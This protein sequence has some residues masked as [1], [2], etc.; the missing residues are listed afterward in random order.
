MWSRPP[1][2]LSLSEGELHVWRMSL[3]PSPDL[4]RLAGEVLSEK[5]KE[6]CARFVRDEDRARCAAAR[7]ALRV[8]LSRYVSQPPG[9][10][11][12]MVG[13]FG[14]PYLSASISSSTAG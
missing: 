3:V 4:A 8:V 6:R 9:S 10:L 12:I 13:K 14:K 5:E 2:E 11:P 7:A 1:R